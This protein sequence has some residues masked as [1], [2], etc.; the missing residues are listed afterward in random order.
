MDTDLY[1]WYVWSDHVKFPLNK[2]QYY[3]FIEIRYVQQLFSV[4]L[5][6]RIMTSVTFLHTSTLWLKPI[7]TQYSINNGFGACYFFITHE[8]N[9]FRTKFFLDS[10][11]Q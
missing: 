1:K 11:S 3:I 9:L 8:N 2:I 7:Y 6:N 5:I 4:K 10:N